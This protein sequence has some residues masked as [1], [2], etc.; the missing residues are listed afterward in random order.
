MEQMDQ[1]IK[2]SL[3]FFVGGEECVKVVLNIGKMSM[4][5]LVD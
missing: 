1:A 3:F 5:D 2:Y 4:V